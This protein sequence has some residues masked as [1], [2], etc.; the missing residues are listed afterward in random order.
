[1][2]IKL[3]PKWLLLIAAICV[4]E[5]TLAA[6][7]EASLVELSQN[8]S[9]Q[10][11]EHR[12]QKVAVVGFSDLNGYRSALGDF[13]SEELV[14]A[15][16]SAGGFDVVERRELD[17]ILSEQSGYTEGIFDIST[18]AEL[19]KLLGIDALITGSITDLGNRVKIN[20]RAIS[21][22]TARAFAAAAVSL[23][24]DQ[25]IQHLMGQAASTGSVSN[26]GGGFSVQRSDVYFKNSFLHL[27]LTGV[28]KS[29]DS[30]RIQFSTE[31]R[32]I[33]DNPIYIATRGDRAVAVISNAGEQ[34]HSSGRPVGLIVN[35]YRNGT[36]E[37]NDY[38]KI[39]PGSHATVL[40]GFRSTSKITGTEF[41]LAFD[42]FRLNGNRVE[43]TTAGLSRI[44][45][46]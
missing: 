2:S 12:I 14:T 16:I 23:E 19:Q 45:L 46:H 39:D 22:E 44:E 7:L 32:N 41:T 38:T 25:T 6:D 11:I 36:T 8:L 37:L 5:N 31:F 20:A 26:A 18:T 13:I 1:M 29:E 10:L 28:A 24:K 3:F 27:V 21:V 15:L 9:E 30:R 42:L 4:A 40:V 43:K 34:F 35:G 33:T 17:R